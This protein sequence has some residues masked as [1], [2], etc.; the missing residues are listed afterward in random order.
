MNVKRPML[1]LHAL[2]LCGCATGSSAG[3]DVTDGEDVE[4]TSMDATDTATRVPTPA[5]T[6]FEDCPAGEREQRLVDVGEVT[7]NVACR[8]AG[9]TV[10]FLHGFPEFHFAWDKVMD[11]LVDEYRLIAPD[12]RGYNL[13]D[14]P[15]DVEAYQLPLL[16]D[17]ILALLPM[18]SPEPVI[19]VAHDWGGP[20]GWLL[21]H[22]PEAHVRGFIAAN[23]PHPVRFAELLATDPAQ[24]QASSYVG[25]FRSDGAEDFLTLDFLAGLFEGVLTPEE[26]T[27][28]EAAWSQ[29]GA[30]TGGLGWYRANLLTPETV[31]VLMADYSPTVVVPTTVLWGLDDA[32]LL[33]PNAEGLE[34]WV[35]D[36]HV[37]TIEGVDHWIEHRIPDE[38]AR[39]IRELDARADAAARE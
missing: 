19:L 20:V 34:A 27:V 31:E 36:L 25:L 33:P 26:L 28:F 14:K 5:P 7:L 38:V 2:L 37:E 9:P 18:V 15:E 4:D 17:D 23:G 39:A 11:E 8:G 21:A 16:V 10:V 24:Q 12:Q 3:V 29:P 13:S 6:W 1:A 30:I 22:H 35:P 32:A